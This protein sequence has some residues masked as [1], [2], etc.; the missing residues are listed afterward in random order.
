MKKILLLLTA[1]LMLF[2]SCSEENP[3]MRID[4]SDG[5]EYSL[6]D[7]AYSFNSFKPVTKEQLYKLE[8][9]VPH[10]IGF[11]WLRHSFTVPPLLKSEDLG[12]YL[13]R[14][15]MADETRVNGMFI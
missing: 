14:I 8:D 12:L 5:W 1:A 2:V 11:I 13:G 10:K 7:P 9:L 3:D 15:T 4:L 6:E